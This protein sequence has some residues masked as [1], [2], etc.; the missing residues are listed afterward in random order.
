[1][2]NSQRPDRSLPRPV[3]Q[4]V[5]R[6]EALRHF[7][8]SEELTQGQQHIKPLHYYVAC[9]LVLEGGFEPDDITPHPPFSVVNRPG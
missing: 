7:A 1:M 4:W 8:L 2:N 3:C 9:R 5:N 6:D